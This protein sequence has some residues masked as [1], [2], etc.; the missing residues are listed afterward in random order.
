MPTK[1]LVTDFAELDQDD[2]NYLKAIFSKDLPQHKRNCL[3]LR[4]GAMLMF[5]FHLSVLLASNYCQD[6]YFITA[7]GI[8]SETAIW[9]FAVAMPFLSCFIFYFSVKANY[10]HVRI[11]HLLF[12]SRNG[13]GLKNSDDQ[14]ER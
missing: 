12:G 8:S 4:F 9:W 2:L 10:Q 14:S 6:D 3:M 11:V 7:Y 5:F 13:T 1:E